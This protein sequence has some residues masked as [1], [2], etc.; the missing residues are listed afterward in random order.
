[1][2]LAVVAAT[3]E[4][5]C[6]LHLR[7]EGGIQPQDLSGL[8]YGEETF[9]DKNDSYCNAAVARESLTEGLIRRSRDTVRSF[10][11]LPCLR[12]C[13]FPDLS[14]SISHQPSASKV[15]NFLRIHPGKGL[16]NYNG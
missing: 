3:G 13:R 10:Q 8:C 14:S 4:Y 7:R 6:H 9:L 5:T 2:A 15:E 11:D 16:D 12:Q 1:M